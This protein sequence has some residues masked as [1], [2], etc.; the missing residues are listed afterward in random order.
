MKK[1]FFKRI[2]AAAI[3]IATIVTTT[4]IP[5]DA[6]VSN[7]IADEAANHV[8]IMETTYSDGSWSTE[9]QNWFADSFQNGS[10]YFK[11]RAPW[12]A[13][14][15]N[16]II[17]SC[18]G[19]A[20]NDYPVT[21]GCGEMLNWYS[22]K[23]LYAER[24]T[25]TPQK[26]DIIFFNYTSNSNITSHV[27]IVESVND[28]KV[29][30][31][32]GNTTEYNDYRYGVRRFTYSLYNSAIKGYAKT[33][34]LIGNSDSE[35]QLVS[36]G[37]YNIECKNGFMTN[38]YA[39]YNYNGARVCM[40]EPDGSVEQKFKLKKSD[41][42]IWYLFAMCS[43][44]G[45]NRVLDVYR[46]NGVTLQQGCAIDLWTNSDLPAQEVELINAGDGYYKIKLVST[47]HI[48]TACGAYNNASIILDNDNNT[49]ETLFKFNKIG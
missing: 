9:Y 14:F 5:A 18:G 15:V 47:G 13:I 2:S 32:E 45:Y 33:S 28:E 29:S 19:E 30:T 7:N 44:N 38:V 26:G 48:F 1:S 37:I 17:N 34:T 24:G 41:N 3:A 21:A 46:N 11:K 36:D 43:S 40:W 20:N 39:G 10:Y 25:Y 23:G 35:Q 27:G 12:C 42:G 31:I 8:G 49:S 22:E 16:Y 6:A 4:I